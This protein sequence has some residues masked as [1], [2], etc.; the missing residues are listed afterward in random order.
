MQQ[1]LSYEILISDQSGSTEIASVKSLA[2]GLSYSDKLW[3][4]VELK[5]GN[6]ITD[7]E[8]GISLE[9]TEID[10]AYLIRV[11]GEDIA[12]LS[13]F[14]E[15]LASHVTNKLGFTNVNLIKDEVL[16]LAETEIYPYIKNVES[17]LKGVLSIKLVQE[18]GVNWWESKL[19][20]SLSNK[21]KE[22]VQKGLYAL[23][24]DEL[25]TLLLENGVGDKVFKSGDVVEKWNELLDVK[26]KLSSAEELSL[27]DI[28][29]AIEIANELNSLLSGQ[30]IE[31]SEKKKPVA[32]KKEAKKQS[33][34]VKKEEAPKAAVKKEEKEVKKEEVKP[35]PV[36]MKEQD[37]S[38]SE[39][40]SEKE[41]LKELK[42]AESNDSSFV[43]L[44][45]FVMDDLVS[46]GYAFGPAYSM[47]KILDESGKVQI[48]DT[49]DE[50]GAQIKAIR[51]L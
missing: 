22:F 17:T 3:E 1:E 33:S 45:M 2:M 36:A 16:Q 38:M 49:V 26:G 32:K 15:P 5:G 35:E 51:S 30:K 9:L 41:L 40:I 31:K 18:Y 42:I 10:E 24:F 8:L 47:S 4:E 34:E 11:T 27:E 44:K 25:S 14:R 6:S 50:N 29:A 48:Y 28:E 21:S 43:N 46:K 39:F 23:S 20:K 12:S 19:P 7:V 37:N 13:S